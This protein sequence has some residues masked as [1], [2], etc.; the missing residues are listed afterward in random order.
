MNANMMEIKRLLPADVRRVFAAWS[1]AE[2]LSR[3]FICAPEWTATTSVD[4]RV[5]GAYRIEMRSGG[6][7]IGKASGQYLE[8][9]PPRRLVFSWTS[10]GGVG[11]RDSVVTVE[12][13]AIGAQTELT[14]THNIAPHTP[15]G[16][17]H[18]A[19]W[20]AC[21]ASLERLLSSEP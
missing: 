15:E 10:E 12:L 9:D 5:G 7:T 4:F 13:K 1:N 3:W 18:A 20:H 2:A 8:I 21:F 19:G 14:L 11:V 6:R 16:R 17:A